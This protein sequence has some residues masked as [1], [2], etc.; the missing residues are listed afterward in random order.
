MSG[1]RTRLATAADRPFLE[2]RLLDAV[3]W[4]PSRTALSLDE[5][6]AL[7][8]IAH[9]VARWPGNRDAGV[10]AS[11][12]G[13][14]VGAAWWTFFSLDDPGYGFVGPDV[15]EVTVGVA[16]DRRGQGVGRA[17][18]LA[19]HEV[20]ESSGIERLSLSV[21]RA[22]FAKNLYRSLGY[23]EVRGDDDAVTMVA[24]LRSAPHE[25]PR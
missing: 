25:H 15:P 6:L 10:V 2:E 5:A 18:L 11:I 22:N 3:N 7:P 24:Q 23:E 4:D 20:A 1:I 8:E 14:D 12:D 17:L 21:E 9:Y 16:R 13:V 19:L